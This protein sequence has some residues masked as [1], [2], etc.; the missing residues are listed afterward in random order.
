MQIGEIVETGSVGFVAQGREL[1]RPPE[2]GSLVKVACPGYGSTEEDRRVYGVVSFGTTTGLDPGRRAVRRSSEEVYDAAIYREHPQLKQVLRTEFN[3][4][5]VG[6][7]AS[8]SIRHHLPPQP[9]PLHYSVR[10]CEPQEVR[11]FSERL[12]YLRLL[13][14]ASDQLPSEQLLAAHLRQ[15]YQARGRDRAWLERAAREVA[16]LLKQD[17]ERLLV[18]LQGIDPGREG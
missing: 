7:A 13:L 10:T 14:T 8:G 9:P 2:L 6:W 1:N 17:V 5:L 11:D 3:V 4:V 16:G 15:V 18:V 12:F